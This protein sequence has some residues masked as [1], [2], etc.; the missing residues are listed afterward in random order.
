M[1]SRIMVVCVLLAGG[2]VWA[3]LWWQGNSQDDQEGSLSDQTTQPIDAETDPDDQNATTGPVDTTTTGGRAR[4]PSADRQPASQPDPDQQLL[5]KITSSDEKTRCD[6]LKALGRVKG[7]DPKL[8]TEPLS[9]DPSP[10]VRQ[11]AARGLGQL[12]DRRS[13]PALMDAL[14]DEDLNV[15]VWAITALHNTL[16]GEIRFP[17]KASGPREQRLLQIDNIRVVMARIIAY[18]AERP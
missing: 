7:T 1:K 8:L 18:R 10:K 12:R 17:Y 3:G 14:D 2:I 15:R 6:A 16:N 5:A 11:A 9:D 4:P 13:I